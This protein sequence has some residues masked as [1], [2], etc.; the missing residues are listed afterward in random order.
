MGIYESENLCDSTQGLNTIQDSFERR[1]EEPIGGK[2]VTSLCTLSLSYVGVPTFYHVYTP[3]VNAVTGPLG[4][5]GMGAL[6]TRNNPE[7]E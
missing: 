4:T 5:V 1:V 7:V 2:S 6:P 3:S